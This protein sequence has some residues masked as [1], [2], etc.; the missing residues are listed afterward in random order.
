MKQRDRRTKKM[1]AAL[2][3]LARIAEI[4][5]DGEEAANII[6]ERAWQHVARP[7]PNHPF[8]AGDY[9]DVDFAPFL[10]LKKTLMRLEKLVLFPCDATAWLKVRGAESEVTPVVHNGTLSRW[11]SFGLSSLPAPAE[12]ATCLARGEIVALEPDAAH[13][14][15]TVLAPMRDSLGDV[16]GAIEFSAR[17]PSARKSPPAW[18]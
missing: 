13:E 3:E 17:P 8:L 7:D 11:Y 4:M 9:Y 16:V 14:M 1:I 15:V 10:R 5:I 18:S 6:T 12:F 2:R